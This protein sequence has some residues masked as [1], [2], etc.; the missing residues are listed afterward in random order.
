MVECF[1]FYIFKD[2]NTDNETIPCLSVFIWLFTDHAI[3]HL[4][5]T[6]DRKQ[7]VFRNRKIPINHPKTCENSLGKKTQILDHRMIQNKIF[8]IL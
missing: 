8:R 6:M 1:G 7:Y 4:T 2:Q 5:L 3:Y